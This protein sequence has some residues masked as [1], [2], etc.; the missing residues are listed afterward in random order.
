MVEGINNEKVTEWLAANVPALEAPE[1]P[2][3]SPDE[4]LRNLISERPDQSLVMLKA[5]LN[6]PQVEEEAAA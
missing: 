6:E 4:A 5:W 1:E 2:E 3:E